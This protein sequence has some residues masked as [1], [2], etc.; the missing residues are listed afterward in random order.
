MMSAIQTGSQQED[1]LKAD[2][3]A[4]VEAALAILAGTSILPEVH[5]LHGDDLCDCWF[6]RIGEWTN[7][8]IGRTLRVRL[9][10]LWGELYKQYPQ[11]VQEIPASYDSNRHQWA[12]EPRAWDSAEASMPLPL[13]Y[14]QLAVKEGK[15]V[16]EIRHE[17][18]DRKRERPKR[19][20]AV[21]AARRKD[22]PTKAEV[23]AAHLARLK[24]TGWIIDE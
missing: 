17:Y 1:Q 19:L 16:G 2:R 22:E 5:W 11:F 3:G 20:S 14:R 15:T 18:Q 4:A 10:C 13:W 8:Y 7:P 21:E 24:A 12:A 23:R 9:C 6:Q